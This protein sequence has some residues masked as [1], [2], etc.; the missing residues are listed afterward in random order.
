MALA[1]KIVNHIL[2]SHVKAYQGN[3]LY[4]FDNEVL[5]TWYPKRVMER[6]P[7]ARSLLELGL[8]HGYTAACFSERFE[9]Y[10]I[11]EGSAAVIQN[12]HEMHPESSPE[13]IETYF[14]NFATDEKFD[15]VVMGFILEH[16]D[17]PVLIM[18]RFRPLLAPGGK[19]YVAVPNAEVLNRRLGNVLGMLDDMT[20]LSE[21]DRLLGHKRYYTVSTLLA[22]VKAAGYKM[23]KMEGI[24]L[25]PFTSRQMIDMRLDK[26]V[27]EALCV[28]GLDFPELC[29][30]MLAEI[31]P[32][33]E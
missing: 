24:Y 18:R 17:D 11:L 13:I 6:A 1:M 30:G 7:N 4:D 32:D 3:S 12:F 28:V 10:V 2:D 20:A 16:V 9:R 5:L 19:M 29:C 8:G 15:V 22:D 26:K 27:I 21:H 23:E 25:K 31:V 33:D 14:E